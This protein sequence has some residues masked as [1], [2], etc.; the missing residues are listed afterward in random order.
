MLLRDTEIELKLTCTDY[1]IW[2][3]IMTAQSLIER[4]VPGSEEKKVLDAHYFDTATYCLKKAKLAYRVRREGEQWVATV[5]GG[6]LSDGGLHQRQEWN[7]TVSDAQPD[8]TVF[9]DTDI[10]SDLLMLVGNQKLEPIVITK[11]ERRTLVVIMPDGSEIEVAADQGT[12]IAGSKNAPI[13]EVELE[14]KSGQ[15]AALIQL[16]AELAREYPLLP[17]QDSK[18]YRGLKLAGLATGQPEQAINYE[19]DKNE[20]A[21]V[22][23]RTVLIQLIAQVLVAQQTFLAQPTLPEHV[24]ELRISLRRL[25][26]LLEFYGPLCDHEK[27]KYHQAELR[28]LGQMLGVLRE[29]DVAY[30]AWEQC[31]AGKF[32]HVEIKANLGAMLAKQRLL[33][34]EKVCVALH[35]GLTTPIL[36]DLWTMLMDNKEQQLMAHHLTVGE[37]SVRRLSGWLETVTKQSKII[38]WTT[39]ENVHKLRLQIKKIKYAVEV[40]EPVFYEVSQLIVRLDTLQYNLGLLSDGNSTVRLLNKLLKVNSRGILHLEVGMVIGWQGRETLT[41]QGKMDKYWQKFYRTAQRWL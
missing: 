12:I 24:H 39:I 15:P 10:G 8:I 41:L 11:F 14:L 18:F 34:G 26:S 33:E 30:A 5:K 38:D 6:G 22:G 32:T 25:R 21:D 29:I 16:G 13:L 40:L 23:L 1:S 3:K 2:G 31:N 20:L 35:A 7:V 4:V 17:E 37:Y 27:C 9:A 19:I 28:K 36:L